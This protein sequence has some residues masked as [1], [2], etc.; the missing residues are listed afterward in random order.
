MSDKYGAPRHHK[1]SYGREEP[2]PH[3]V[4]YAI[5]EDL[6]WEHFTYLSDAEAKVAKLRD[7]PEINCIIFARTLSYF[8]RSLEEVTY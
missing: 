7:N 6:K 5:N 8:F 4:C 2:Q 3:I 1:H